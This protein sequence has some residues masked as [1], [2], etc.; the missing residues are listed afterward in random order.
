MRV[1]IEMWEIDTYEYI[2]N[3]KEEFGRVE[4]RLLTLEELHDLYFICQSAIKNKFSFILGFS[5]CLC[6]KCLYK[7]PENEWVVLFNG[8][9]G[10][11]YIYGIFDNIYDAY[12]ALI[13][14]CVLKKKI[15]MM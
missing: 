8:D 12:L 15:E 10:N 13:N 3:C 9:I 2:K 1:E 11:S 6:S 7:T 4:E 5:P 14:V